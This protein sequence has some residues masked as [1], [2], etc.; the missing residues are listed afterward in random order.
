MPSGVYP[1][2]PDSK[3]GRKPKFASS[4]VERIREMKSVGHSTK[5][6][7]ALWRASEKTIQHVV[8]KTH[9]YKELT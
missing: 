3:P 7:A 8:A 6:L 4:Q 9:A 1:R 5:F 2:K